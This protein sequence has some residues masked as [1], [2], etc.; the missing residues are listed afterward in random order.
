MTAMTVRTT[1]TRVLAAVLLSLLTLLSGLWL[2]RLGKPYN[3]WVMILHTCIALASILVI[4]II[5]FNRHKA[6]ELTAISVL[7]AIVLGPKLARLLA[8]ADAGRRDGAMLEILVLQALA[9]Q[10]GGD[11]LPTLTSLEKTTRLAGPGSYKHTV[12]GEGSPM[13]ALLELVQPENG[14]LVRSV[15]TRSGEVMR[16]ESRP[17]DQQPL[18]E[19]LS[20]R[21][22]EVLEQI[23]LGLTN[24]EIADELY[25]S[26][27]TVKVHT[28]NIY[29]K[30][31]VN[32][33]TQAVNEAR[34][35]SLISAA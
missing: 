32:S 10:A 23:D 1:G 26:L 2:S 4:I 18:V 33:R 17:V 24:R 35:L 34:S 9:L 25:I 19:P 21:E 8:A 12:S 20:E 16:R 29:G 22:I 31:G 3:I 11:P 13:A 28:R 7:A 6:L 14:R 5:G 30:L 27:N 15:H